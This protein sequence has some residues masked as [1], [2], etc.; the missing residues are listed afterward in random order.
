[1]AYTERCTTLD[2]SFVL[3]NQSR[4][5]MASLALASRLLAFAHIRGKHRVDDSLSLCKPDF[6]IAE[7]YDG[8]AALAKSLNLT[9]AS[10]L[11]SARESRW[12]QIILG[13]RS[14]A[15]NVTMRSHGHDV[16]VNMIQ[17]EAA[18]DVYDLGSRSFEGDFPAWRHRCP[19][20]TTVAENANDGRQV[21]IGMRQ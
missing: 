11:L 16:M 9:R 12:T 17:R 3:R 5:R 10:R 19:H 4:A 13:S 7:G 15:I 20:M 1:M 14:D 8:L 21:L 18:K 2:V 6:D